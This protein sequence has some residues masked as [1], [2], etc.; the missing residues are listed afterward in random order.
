MMKT[1]VT[2]ERL[3]RRGYMSCH[4]YF[5]RFTPKG[6]FQLDFEFC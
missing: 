6:N 4:D 3:T 2:I 5:Q 1:T